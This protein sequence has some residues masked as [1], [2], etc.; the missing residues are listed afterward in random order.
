[1]ADLETEELYEELK[2]FKKTKF[3]KTREELASYMSGMMAVIFDWQYDLLEALGNDCD[4][5]VRSLRT[6]VYQF[7]NNVAANLNVLRQSIKRDNQ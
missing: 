6:H 2:E 1:M 4:L 5:S 7:E 3:P